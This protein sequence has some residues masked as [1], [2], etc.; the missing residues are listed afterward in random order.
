MTV[1]NDNF[2]KRFVL[3]AINQT[4]ATDFTFLLE[5][6]LAVTST[7]GAILT[8]LILNSDYT[9]TRPGQLGQPGSVT[10]TPGTIGDTITIIRC[11]D[12]TH[13]TEYIENGRFPA[14][15]VEKD[16]DKVYMLACKALESIFGPDSIVLHYPP[17]EFGITSQVPKVSDRIGPGTGTVFGWNNQGAPDVLSKGSLN[18]VLT[19]SN[20]SNLG[21]ATPDT[22]NGVTQAAVK[23]YI[24]AADGLISAIQSA[25]ITAM[26]LNANGTWN[27][28][29]YAGTTF[30]VGT[31]SL[32][33]ALIRL[34]TQIN[35]NALDITA[36]AVSVQSLIDQLAAGVVLYAKAEGVPTATQLGA[37]PVNVGDI[38]L[39]LPA[40]RKWTHV[41]VEVTNERTASSLVA[42]TRIDAN[43]VTQGSRVQNLSGTYGGPGETRHIPTH[44]IDYLPSAPT[45]NQ[46]IKVFYT[47]TAADL[48]GRALHAVGH[49]EAV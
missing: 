18:L 3:T 28:S 4:L 34:D 46:S 29:L 13:I 10:M 48:G 24:D 27:I 15:V 7:A 43:A 8:P 33:D 38:T 6:D 22:V 1:P 42:F 36:L 45:A 41:R 5:K 2:K 11:P 16:F 40:G 9:V 14:K 23:I 19:L 32:P 49:H 17:T 37:A 21:G 31:T 35:T 30:L 20:D 44:T 26:G 39:T 25:I 47:G 12:C